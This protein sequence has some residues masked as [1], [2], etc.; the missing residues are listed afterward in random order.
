MAIAPVHGADIYSL[1][2]GGPMGSHE[3]ACIA[4]CRFR[5]FLRMANLEVENWSSRAG[6][7]SH[8]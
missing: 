6:D 1:F 5:E 8:R 3:G 4:V 7:V 2:L